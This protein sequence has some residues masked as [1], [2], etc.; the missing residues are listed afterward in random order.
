MSRKWTM[1]R[2]K[3]LAV[4]MMG[5]QIAAATSVARASDFDAEAVLTKMSTVERAAYIAG[6]VEGLAY[7]RYDKDGQTTDGMG[8]IYDWLYENDQTLPAIYAAFERFPNYTPGAIIA[9]M[10][11]KECGS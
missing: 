1:G 3:C 7:A 2:S 5:L 6:V 8:C 11:D 9:A 10:V 4:V